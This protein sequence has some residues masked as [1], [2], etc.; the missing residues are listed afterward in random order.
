MGIWVRNYLLHNLWDCGRRWN[1]APTKM[2]ISHNTCAVTGGP[3]P[4]ADR[5]CNS[6]KM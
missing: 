6:L 3:R 1:A 5:S 2:L 4:V